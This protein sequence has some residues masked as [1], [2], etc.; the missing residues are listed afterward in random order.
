[1]DDKLINTCIE[2]DKEAFGE[3]TSQY[4]KLVMST[5]YSV[6]NRY[7]IPSVAQDAEDL[8]NSLFLSLMDNDFRKLKQFKGES[9]F[10]TYI[11]V[12]TVRFV[13]DFLRKEK[14]RYS[15]DSID[16]EK[17]IPPLVEKSPAH[18]EVLEMT[19]T[20]QEIKKVIDSLSPNE[21]LLVKLVYY[22]ELSPKEV[23]RVM[24]ISIVT[25]Y[26]KKSRI[27]VKLRKKCK[28]SLAAAS[29]ETRR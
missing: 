2:G 21:R 4:T 6:F 23:S 10:S 15:V 16:S 8:H 14:K 1:M 26:S 9:R 11:R 17:T 20:E 28:K 13:I 24:G 5:I 27:L 7:S 29:N 18:D 12:I 19:E 3:L 22:K 25:F